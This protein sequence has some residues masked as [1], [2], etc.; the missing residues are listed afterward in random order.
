MHSALYYQSQHRIVDLLSAQIHVSYSCHV[1][2][3]VKRVETLEWFFLPSWSCAAPRTTWNSPSVTN[4]TAPIW[5][6][7]LI[8]ELQSRRS[9]WWRRSNKS[10]SVVRNTVFKSVPNSLSQFN[11]SF[12]IRVY[13]YSKNKQ[14][15]IGYNLHSSLNVQS[16][17]QN[18]EAT[19]A[20]RAPLL[21][22]PSSSSVLQLLSYRTTTSSASWA[23]WS[24]HFLMLSWVRLGST[25]IGLVFWPSL[26]IINHFGRSYY[27]KL[28]IKAYG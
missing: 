20:S 14:I 4:N 7:T 26:T 24:I 1:Q 12:T 18:L 3:P 23:E 11:F 16:A 6:P 25:S 13:L 15:E 2:L 22:F 8:T 17:Q 9:S 27:F 28:N 19:E 10:T 21:M 5:G